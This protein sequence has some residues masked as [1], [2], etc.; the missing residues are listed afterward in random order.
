M[1]AQPVDA[2]FIWKMEAASVFKPVYGRDPMTGSTVD[3]AT[4]KKDQSYSKDYLQ[5]D[6]PGSQVLERVLGKVPPVEDGLVPIKWRWPGGEVDGALRQHDKIMVRKDLS[7]P[8]NRPP[9]PWR[10]K[11][12]PQPGDVE[13]LAGTPNLGTPQLADQEFARIVATGEHPWLLGVHLAGEGSIL[14]ARVVFENPSAAHAGASW[15]LVPPEVKQ[16]AQGFRSNQVM[17]VVEYRAGAAM[18][19]TLV[20]RILAAF[21]DSPNVLLVGPPGTGKTVAMEKVAALYSSTPPS[22]VTF[23][24]DVLHAAFGSGAMPPQGSRRLASLLFHPSYAYEHFVMGL[25]PEVVKDASG[26][27][28]G[29]V[30]V[31][32]KV[33]PLLELAQFASTA[34]DNKALL[35]L[36][37]FN[38]GNAAAIF[39]DTLALLDRD[40]RDVASIDTPYVHLKPGTSLGP[41]GST[42]SLPTDLHVLAA[43]NSA[44]RSVAPLDAA[45]RR[46]FSILHVDPDLEAL[47]NELKPDD[48]GVVLDDPTTWA[49]G[50]HVASVAIAILESLNRR[51]EFVL[52]RDFLLGQSVFWHLN[53]ADVDSALESLAVALDNRVLGTLTLSFTDDDEG[54]AAV[55]NVNV[56]SRGPAAATWATPP[57]ELTRWPSRLRVSRFQDFSGADLVQALVSL[58][59]A[60]VIATHVAT[61]AAVASAEEADAGDSDATD[62]GPAADD[63][64]AQDDEDVEA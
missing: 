16:V 58:L 21:E 54:L 2:I 22:G 56:A 8:K 7:W 33:G 28:T 11:P 39:G 36:D 37:E 17:G 50:E 26:N 25:L 57:S 45:L 13:V 4:G 55:L 59:D 9:A 51:I 18:T 24:P 53:T 30:T 47:R 64:S 44:D 35:V 19:D 15:D 60:T 41:L 38:R 6:T 3:P 20:Q 14:H 34:P 62:D 42:T 12:S 46:R 10:L 1:T 29:V 49:T 63:A 40:K 27:P 31:S 32:P 23:D 52:G 48:V 61:T 43:M 5:P